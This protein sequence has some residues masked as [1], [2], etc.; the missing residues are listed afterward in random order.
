M[1]FVKTLSI[2]SINK[3]IKSF[4]LYSFLDIIERIELNI[5]I[6]SF[7]TIIFITI[8][9][10]CLKSENPK[11]LATKAKTIIIIKSKAFFNN[12]IQKVVNIN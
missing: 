11:P 8:V 9:T 10:N 4:D 7:K 1:Y 12:P 3:E 6:P 5:D 2:F